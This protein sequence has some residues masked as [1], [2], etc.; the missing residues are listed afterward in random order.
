MP[1]Q[2]KYPPC[3]HISHCAA[4]LCSRISWCPR[5][6][7]ILCG[8]ILAYRASW[9]ALSESLPMLHRLVPFLV[10]F[11]DPCYIIFEPAPSHC[12]TALCCGSV[13]SSIFLPRSCFTFVR[14]RCALIVSLLAA[15]TAFKRLSVRDR[16][17]VI[18]C[19]EVPKVDG[20]A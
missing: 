15:R 2:A 13:F 12:F 8:R 11:D 3:Y 1:W 16:I 17:K 6:S 20:S 10:V 14:Q 9:L 7:H 5:F 18:G 4:L 19:F